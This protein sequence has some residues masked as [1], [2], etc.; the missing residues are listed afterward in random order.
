MDTALRFLLVEDSEDD[1]QLILHEL[2]RRGYDPTHKRIETPEDMRTALTEHTWDVILCDYVMPH[3]SGLAALKLF[4]ES[5]LDLPFIIVSGRI[6]E[7]VAV[8]AMRAGAHDYILKHNLT[9]LV[10]AIERELREAEVR[11]ER[12]QAAEALRE[13]EEKYRTILENIEEGYYEVDLSGNYTFFNKSL[14]ELLGRSEDELLGMNYRQSMDSEEAEGVFQTF[15]AVYRT[16]KPANAFNW[17]IIRTNGIRRSIEASIS[18][19]ADSAGEPAGFCGLARDVTERNEA[20]EA[21]KE[22]EERYRT[23]LQ[24]MHDLVF[25]HDIHDHYVQYYTSSKGLLFVSP[26]EFMGK[27]VRDVLP[28][29]VAEQYLKSMQGVRISG[30]SETID[31]ALE[32]GGQEYWFSNTLSLHEDGESIVAVVRDITDRK[33]VAEALRESEERLRQVINL[34]PHHVFVKSSEGQFILLNEAVAE[35]YGATVDALL[36][37]LQSD[38]HSDPRQVETFLQEDAEVLETGKQLR[39]PDEPFTHSDGTVHWLDTRKIPIQFGDHGTCILG[40]ALDITERKRAEEALRESEEWFR[41]IYE[42]SPIA[43]NVFDSDGNLIHA[44]PAL[45]DFVGVSSVEELKDFNVFE[46]PNVPE[47]VKQRMRKGERILFQSVIDF[48]KVKEAGLYDTSKS[49]V[50]YVDAGASPLRHGEDESLRG[51]M[52]QM[53]D[54]TE[55]VLAEANTKAAAETA[56][57]YLDLMGHDIRNHLQAIIMGTEILEQ[58]EIRP[59]VREMVDLVVDSVKNSQNLIKKVQATRDLLSVPLSNT[60]LREALEDCLQVLNE[61]YDDVQ[62]E[63]KW[64]PQHPIVLADEYLGNLLMNILENAVLHNDKKKRRVWL[65]LREVEGGYEVAIADNGP[66]IL[67]ER[68]E[69]LFDQDRRFGGV[70]VHQ[71]LKIAQKYGGH[72]TVQDRVPG[73]SSKGAEF[74]IWFPKSTS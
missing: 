49:G 43:I 69:S 12:K 34:I 10:P 63:V 21:L 73:D 4:K 13:S 35:S 58:L 16:G 14:C 1:V 27:Y 41:A 32:I 72:I 28:P 74:H 61:T 3:F 8:D 50:S 56:M 38:V 22:S 68:K 45:I 30:E 25:V 70:G 47:D 52:V 7:E 46:D 64:G 67:D 15:N 48:A 9:R 57:L 18:L 59:E 39:I 42:E 37:R 20:Q 53:V 40:V 65:S 33:Q 2:R 55:R 66:G 44:N 31:Y 11:T 54:I 23:L 19:V 62:I 17:T 29:D 24:S 5:G 60:S 51:Y 6:G 71:V 26:E 36:G